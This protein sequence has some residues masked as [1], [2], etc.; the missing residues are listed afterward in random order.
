MHRKK[1]GLQLFSDVSKSHG[2]VFLNVWKK[3]QNCC[4]KR[5]E[6]CH[7][8]ICVQTPEKSAALLF[9]K[10]EKVIALFI[11][12]SNCRICGTIPLGWNFSVNLLRLGLSLQSFGNH[13]IWCFCSCICPFA[14]CFARASFRSCVR[15]F[16]RVLKGHIFIEGLKMLSQ[17]AG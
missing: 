7:S 13:S 10:S 11:V 2:V 14:R 15:S 1:A 8:I 5:S 17:Q 9:Q 3:S 4:F 12:Y 16:K 6:K